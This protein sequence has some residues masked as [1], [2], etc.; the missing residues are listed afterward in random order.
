VLIVLCD[1]PFQQWN[2][3]RSDRMQ[4]R[5]VDPLQWHKTAKANSKGR[6]KTKRQD[7]HLHLTARDKY[8]CLFI[9]EPMCARTP[10]S[11]GCVSL[12]PPW[13]LEDRTHPGGSGCYVFYSCPGSEKTTTALKVFL[14]KLRDIV[15]GRPFWADGH[16][17]F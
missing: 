1:A 5:T 7:G 3:E 2:A 6:R 16:W 8:F 4:R 12:R 17:S 14:E 10:W 13:C 11:A 15:R 9:L